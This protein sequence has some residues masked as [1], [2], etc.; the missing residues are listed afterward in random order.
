[1]GLYDINVMDLNDQPTSLSEY[2]G[3]VLLIINTAIKCGF[4]PQYEGLQTLYQK[5]HDQG[6]EIL[7]FRVTSSPCRRREPSRRFTISV[8]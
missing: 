6:F 4:T 5:Y 2:K 8:P 7:D 3:K 1:M